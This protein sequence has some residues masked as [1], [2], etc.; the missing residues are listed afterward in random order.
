[1]S[2]HISCHVMCHAMSR[3]VIS[4]HILCHVVSCHV[5]SC[6]HV[7][8]WYI[9]SLLRH[10][11]SHHI[12]CHVISSHVTSSH[13]MSWPCCVRWW[14]LIRRDRPLHDEW[15]QWTS[16]DRSLVDRRRRQSNIS[17]T[18][19]I[20]SVSRSF[21]MKSSKAQNSVINMIENTGVVRIFTG[22]GYWSTQAALRLKHGT[23][24]ERSRCIIK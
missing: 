24:D 1:M 11:M 9:M 18:T 16:F 13:V 22:G 21:W 7:M 15:R 4:Y 20:T 5:M 8:S 12:S 10:D 2:C 23:L 19:G 14:S 3:C 6:H 17:I